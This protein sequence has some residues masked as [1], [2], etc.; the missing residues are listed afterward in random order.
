[1]K[2]ERALWAPFKPPKSK[3]Q[4]ERAREKRA[5][6]LGGTAEPSGHA[7]EAPTQ[8]ATSPVAMVVDN[9]DAPEAVEQAVADDGD[10]N[11]LEQTAGAEVSHPDNNLEDEVELEY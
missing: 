11:M 7:N 9:E 8:P 10:A 4:K 6:R 2:G 5:A 3:G 1:M